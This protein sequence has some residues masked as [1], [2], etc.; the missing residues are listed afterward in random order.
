SR[1]S[2]TAASMMDSPSSTC[3]A[4]WLSTSEPLMRSSTIRNRSS[5]CTTAATVRSGR[6][7]MPASIGEAGRAGPWPARGGSVARRARQPHLVEFA[8]VVLRHRRLLEAGHAVVAARL[9]AIH[10]GAAVGDQ[11]AL[12]APGILLHDAAD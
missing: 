6:Q 2:R 4:G 3:P 10:D 5:R 9:R 11:H 8:E 12:R 1:V 7:V